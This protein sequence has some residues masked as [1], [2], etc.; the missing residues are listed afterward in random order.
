MATMVPLLPSGVPISRRY[1]SWTRRSAARCCPKARRL[2]GR[3][4][5]AQLVIHTSGSK[6]AA[7]LRSPAA[8]PVQEERSHR[9]LPQCNVCRQHE[10][11]KMAVETGP[12]GSFAAA[13]VGKITACKHHR[14]VWSVLM[15]SQAECAVNCSGFI[16]RRYQREVRHG[17]EN[18]LTFGEMSSFLR[19]EKRA[20]SGYSQFLHRFERTAIILVKPRFPGRPFLLLEKLRRDARNLRRRHLDALPV[21]ATVRPRVPEKPALAVRR[22]Q[23]EDPPLRRRDHWPAPD[24]DRPAPA[25]RR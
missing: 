16:A 3:R 21:I 11:E 7:A 9:T 10:K 12:T 14:S 8:A 18:G 22:R 24:T 25:P 17:R 5:G 4:R 23:T 15:D 6:S 20:K 19:A 13:D 2:A 1:A